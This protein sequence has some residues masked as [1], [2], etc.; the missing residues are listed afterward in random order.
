MLRG[1]GLEDR[2]LEI[3]T[4]LIEA[5]KKHKA[6]IF[7]GLHYRDLL[8]EICMDNE[9][10][11]KQLFAFIDV[12]PVLKTDD[13]VEQHFKEYLGEVN[14]G[15]LEP[16]AKGPLGVKSLAEMIANT[17]I[18]G[19]DID[20]TYSSISRLRNDGA[21]FTLDILGE[22]TTSEKDADAYKEKY[23]STLGDLAKKFENEPVDR[24]GKPTVNMSVKLSA[25]YS[26]FDPIDQEGTSQA[27]K[28]RLREI[29]RKARDIGAAINID[30][31]QYRF[32]DI[33]QKIFM[34]LMQEDEFKDYKHAGIVVQAYTKD[35]EG[36]L[37]ELLKWSK[38][39]NRSVNI[40][41]V[42]GAYWDHEQ[43]LAEMNGW[44]SPVFEEKYQ[45]DQNFEKLTKILLENTKKTNG[46]VSAA[47]ASHNMRSI[48]HALALKEELG[49]SNKDFEI[50][51]LYGMGDEIR[52]ALVEK[53][54][55][56]R[57]YTPMGEAIP[58]MGYFVRRLLENSSN[59]SFLRAFDKTADANELLRNPSPEAYTRKVSLS[60]VLNAA[61]RT[62]SLSNIV[63]KAVG[64]YT[65]L[66]HVKKKDG[67][68]YQ[69]EKTPFKNF[70]VYDFSKKEN[71]AAMEDALRNV[72]DNFGNYNYKL[73][74]NGK[75]VDTNNHKEVLN[76]S[77]SQVIGRVAMANTSSIDDALAASKEAFKKWRYTKAEER[78]E[79]LF[80]VAKNMEDRVFELAALMVYEAGK[81]W[82]EA[83]A[84]VAEAID[85]LN[86]YGHEMIKLGKKFI[87]QELSAEENYIKYIPK[88]TVAVISPWNFPLAIT[89][90]MTAAAIVTGNTVLLK[91]ASNTPLIAGE[92][93][94]MFKDAGLPDGV[95]NYVPG[96]GSEIG[97]HLIDSK[98]TNMVA[99]TGSKEV[100]L[101][102]HER[103]SKTPE[104]QKHV[105]TDILEMGGKDGI[106][107][108][109]TADLDDAVM[110]ALQ[111]A[112]GYQGQKCSACSRVII[113]EAV[114]DK[115]IDKLIEGARSL[116]V[117]RADLHGTDVG[118][119]INKTAYNKI[120]DYI[121]R[122][123]S[124]KEGGVIRLDGR[125]EPKDFP[126]SKGSYICPTLIEVGR[127]NVIAQE[128]VFGPVVS[129]MK[130][131]DF[132]EAM[133]I[134]NG[135]GY[136]LTGGIY[137][138]T[139]SHE[140]RFEEEAEVGN[141]YVNRGITG[142]IVQRQP[143][144][145]FKL[146]GAGSKAGGED[147]LKE[148]MYEKTVSIN[149][150]RGGVFEAA[151]PKK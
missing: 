113:H 32:R 114:Y 2:I 115:F 33:T 110:G 120:H 80:K 37:D 101:R 76:P 59:E 60:S 55:P 146:S 46:Q 52:K 17:F 68:V 111:S 112:F 26:R 148:F 11:K 29:F 41:L 6:G 28:S 12:L 14:L 109:A 106:I 91:P 92:L 127:N 86:F 27:V 1:K 126:D 130:A 142:A 44:E 134:H 105:K 35:S 140:K 116:R 7:S 118:P 48:T 16:L 8:F 103:I 78:A 65:S 131:K 133:E 96:S 40:R 77:T 83:Y 30:A 81:T 104:K 63:S 75:D 36:A 149:R 39:E 45:T 18:A 23:I 67:V 5:A 93:M 53:D 73:H 50:Q 89:T 58:G 20:K 95:L 87:T 10:L 108:D 135:T 74:I 88:G 124:E 62:L 66:G 128:E 19:A 138:R 4:P 54:T 38:R 107:V 82:K 129:V 125:L 57:V 98:L 132:Y 94:S 102:I 9:E 139:P 150:Q 84:D 25:L 147:Y 42:K 21:S 100:G 137:S 51:L 151:T 119:I 34:E 122:A 56:V 85:F 47:I 144:G 141:A 22:K 90:G 70:P 143:F 24:Y 61:R 31:E 136:A 121:K 13:G 43:M 145:G 79:Y 49:I 123:I 71:R 97:D 69:R 3:G 99:F 64:V 117:G 15:L 72:R